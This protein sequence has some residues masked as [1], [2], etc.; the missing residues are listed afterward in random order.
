M[1]SLKHKEYSQVWGINQE[2]LPKENLASPLNATWGLPNPD[3][4][5]R[6]ENCGLAHS[7]CMC[8]SSK[9]L[10]PGLGQ[11]C[12]LEVLLP[13]D[14]DQGVSLASPWQA[15]PGACGRPARLVGGQG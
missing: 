14:G 1:E 7:R 12:G 5:A 3:R 9:G 10:Y 2:K 4:K 6:N 13:E 8:S 15:T 11:S